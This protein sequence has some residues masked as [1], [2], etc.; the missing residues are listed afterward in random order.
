M[1]VA[2]ITAV[3][4]LA[5]EAMKTAMGA[6]EIANNPE[7]TAEDLKRFRDRAIA[8][9]KRLEDEIAKAIAREEAGG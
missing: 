5:M 9:E 1:S 7:A 6:L 3:L 4:P 2:I 8:S